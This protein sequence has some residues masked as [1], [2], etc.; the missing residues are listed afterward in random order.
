MSGNF[1][2]YDMYL[3]VLVV[4]RVKEDFD[5]A[6]YMDARVYYVTNT[7]TIMPLMYL[8]CCH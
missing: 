8:L 3:Y 4:A 6:L 1:F 5:P 2:F 7:S